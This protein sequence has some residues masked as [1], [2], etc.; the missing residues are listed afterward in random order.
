MVILDSFHGA[1]HVFKELT[2]LSPFVTLGQY[3]V[4]EDTNLNGNPI[5]PNFGP[6][7]NEALKDWIG[8]EQGKCFE[9]QTAVETKYG[10]SFFPGGWLRRIRNSE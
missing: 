8:S 6:G 10:Y 7:P 1:L 3:L 5:Q 9:N 2:L 4:V